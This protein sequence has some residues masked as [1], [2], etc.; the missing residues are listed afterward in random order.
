MERFNP[1]HLEIAIR[2]AHIEDMFDLCDQ[3]IEII[4]LRTES[5]LKAVQAAVELFA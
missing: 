3:Q 4:E 5:L 2:L 1:S